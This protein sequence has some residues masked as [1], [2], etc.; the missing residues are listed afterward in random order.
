MSKIMS[1][2]FSN[3]PLGAVTLAYLAITMADVLA[4]AQQLAW[5]MSSH[6]H[7]ACVS[8]GATSAWCTLKF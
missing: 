8:M 1:T 5:L 4:Y 2:R 6:M 3:A 7:R